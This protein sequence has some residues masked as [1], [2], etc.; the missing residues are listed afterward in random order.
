MPNYRIKRAPL[1]DVKFNENSAIIRS[2]FADWCP[3][4][5]MMLMASDKSE[6]KFRCP[7]CRALTETPAKN[8]KQVT[9][10]WN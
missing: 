10:S 8:R 2:K 5:D 1:A 9:A 6:G 3:A 7:R 4:C